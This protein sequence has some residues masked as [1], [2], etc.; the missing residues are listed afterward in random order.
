MQEISELEE[1]LKLVDGI[2]EGLNDISE[3]YEIAVEEK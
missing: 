1:Q 3:F 2:T